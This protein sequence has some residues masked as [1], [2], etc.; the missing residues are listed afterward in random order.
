MLIRYGT[1]ERPG[2]VG[3]SLGTIAQVEL[4]QHT[5]HV[6][7]GSLAADDQAPGNLG[8][9]EAEADESEYFLLAP[10][11]KTDVPGP[12]PTRGAQRA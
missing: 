9:G 2:R 1:A 3:D 4:G 8:V 12:G 7:G 11:E 5:A 6:V 10:G